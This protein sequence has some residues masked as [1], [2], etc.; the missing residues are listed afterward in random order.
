MQMMQ[1]SVVGQRPVAGS[2][3]SLVVANVAEVTRPAVST[4]GK[5]RVSIATWAAQHADPGLTLQHSCEL[6][7]PVC[8]RAPPSSPLR[9]LCSSSP[10]LTQAELQAQFGSMRRLLA[11]PALAPSPQPPQREL[12]RLRS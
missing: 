4:N 6:R 1:R 8:R 3:R 10:D 2:R 11:G 5:H 7:R 12:P 9:Y